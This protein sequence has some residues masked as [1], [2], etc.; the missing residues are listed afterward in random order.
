VISV[1]DGE[2]ETDLRVIEASEDSPTNGESWSEW[3]LET[4]DLTRMDFTNESQELKID[5]SGLNDSDDIFYLDSLRIDDFGQVVETE[6]WGIYP[7]EVIN[8]SEYVDTG[9]WLGWLYVGNRANGWIYSFTTSS[10]FWFLSP[11]GELNSG[12]WVYSLKD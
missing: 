1:I 2:H 8:G 10:W 6:D 9:D 4:L 3:R 11:P 12:S 5:A 7:V